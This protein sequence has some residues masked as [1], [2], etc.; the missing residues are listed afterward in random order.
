MSDQIL[1]NKFL[2]EL[3][4]KIHIKSPTS[5]APEKTLLESFKYYD[6]RKTGQ[7]DYKTFTKMVKIKLSINI[8]KNEELMIIY[9]CFQNRFDSGKNSILYREFV[10]DLYNVDV[11]L[12]SVKLKEEDLN[13]L[14][15]KTKSFT[16]NKY[17]TEDSSKIPKKL[18]NF[19]IYKLRK[20]S[21]S[22]FLK[23][24]VEMLNLDQSE[25]GFLSF[26][27][28]FRSLNKCGVDMKEDSVELIWSYFQNKLGRMEYE[29]FWNFLAKNYNKERK[30]IVLDMFGKLDINY[31]KCIDINILRELFNP[32]N[33]FDVKSQRKTIEE[34]QMSFGEYVNLFPITCRG[35]TLL[36]EYKFFEFFK[37]ISIYIEKDKDFISFIEKGFRY[38]ELKKYKLK[39]Q[40]GF[41]SK[42]QNLDGMRNGDLVS[43]RSDLRPDNILLSL[44]E[45]LSK[46]GN[47]GYINFFKSLKGND[48]DRDGKLYLKEWTKTLKEQRINLE[49]RQIST[50]FKHYSGHSQRMNFE[51][52]L[53]KLIPS[54]S[55][56]RIQLLKSLYEDLFKGESANELTFYRLQNSFN[57]RGHPD[58]RDCLRADYEIKTEFVE[59]LQTFLLN[60]QGNHI[61]LSLF[62]FVRFFEFFARDWNLDFFE[63]VLENSFSQRARGSNKNTIEAPYGKTEDLTKKTFGKKSV[64]NSH[65]SK[66][67][68]EFIEDKKSYKPDYPYYTKEKNKNAFKKKTSQLDNYKENDNKMKNLPKVES[69]RFEISRK[70]TNRK[71]KDSIYSRTRQNNIHQ[72]PNSPENGSLLSYSK[73]EKSIYNL[74]K[75]IQDSIVQKDNRIYDNLNPQNK[76]GLNSNTKKLTNLII[77][78][79]S[80]ATMLELEYELTNKS[81]LKGTIDFQSFATVF[82]KLKLTSNLALNDL[83]GS[84]TN[85]DNILHVQAFVNDLRGQ[86][87][88]DRENNVI[89][90]FE[91]LCSKFGEDFVKVEKFRKCFVAREFG[92]SREKSLGEVSEMFEFMIDLFV[93]LN[94]SIKERD[95]FDLDDFLYFFDNFSFFIEDSIRFRNMLRKCFK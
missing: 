77:T 80:L 46:K 18:L 28:L 44:E 63:A 84:N 23:L 92:Y 87:D 86:M 7:I 62:A 19:I 79:K 13:S 78:E 21:F 38:Y 25:S 67:Y 51:L 15:S 14:Y 64:N 57:A 30:K 53:Q 5:I 70:S 66:Y 68:D 9:D 24:Y 88:E 93:C 85:E 2:K 81:D 61:S 22:G 48:F 52:L 40:S 60:F 45:Q 29:R 56:K 12:N 74:N 95:F 55:T 72:A 34:I 6:F 76:M 49:E 75:K 36:D 41:K 58:F 31:Q 33:Y 54:Y 90:L 69:K 73:N 10:K 39:N 27:N 32:K 35:N 71:E 17:D 89:D 16:G 82:Q 47:K 11:T 8:F 1:I 20:K 3:K 65:R 94:L 42:I 26:D 91:R 83:Y 37:F 50:I 59:S 43:L 4:H